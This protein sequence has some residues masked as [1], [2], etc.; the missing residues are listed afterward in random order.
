MTG[1]QTTMRVGRAYPLAISGLLYLNSYKTAVAVA[2]L[3]FTSA[4]PASRSITFSAPRHRV[5]LATG[6]HGGVTNLFYNGTSC[7]QSG[8]SAPGNNATLTVSEVG[9]TYVGCVNASGSPETVGVGVGAAAVTLGGYCPSYTD[10]ARGYVMTTGATAYAV[11]RALVSASRAVLATGTYANRT[12]GVIA[13]ALAMGFAGEFTFFT[14]Y[15]PEAITGDA[16]WASAQA[17]AVVGVGSIAQPRHS[18]ATAH[19]L[20]LRDAASVATTFSATLSPGLTLNAWQLLA[21]TYSAGT[22]RWYIDGVQ[23]GTAAG[24]DRVRTAMDAAYIGSRV[25]YPSGTGALLCARAVDG[26]A[27]RALTAAELAALTTWCR[28]EYV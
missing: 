25:S 17:G 22:A 3:T 8:Y 28:S 21:V 27:S 14:Y 11:N 16:A 7:A 12:L 15:R 4:G 24:T 5:D 1:L 19:S 13:P 9:T 18:S 20:L 2:P 6:W 10:L 23:V 26:G